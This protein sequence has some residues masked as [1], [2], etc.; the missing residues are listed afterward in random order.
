M[1]EEAT[2]SLLAELEVRFLAHDR[3]NQLASQIN[4]L[5]V[6]VEKNE[7]AGAQRYD[8]LSAQV[9]RNLIVAKDQYSRVSAQVAQLSVGIQDSMTVLSSQLAQ[10]L[11]SPSHNASPSQIS[12]PLPNNPPNNPVYLGTKITITQS[13]RGPAGETQ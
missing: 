8:H 2:Q 9:E 1:D 13:L 3:V 6:Q 10:A 4:Q 5:G 12:H 11:P 7:A